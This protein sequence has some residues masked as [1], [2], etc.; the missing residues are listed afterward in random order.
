MGSRGHCSGRCSLPRAGSISSQSPPGTVTYSGLFMLT[1]CGKSIS[2]VICSRCCFQ[3]FNHLYSTGEF[4]RLPE[5]SSCSPAE[6]PKPLPLSYCTLQDKKL[7]PGGL[8]WQNC[9]DDVCAQPWCKGRLDPEGQQSLRFAS[10]IIETFMSSSVRRSVLLGMIGGR[11]T[12]I[13]AP[14]FTQHPHPHPHPHAFKVFCLRFL[15]C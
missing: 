8:F 4:A 15:L 14:C 5:C 11:M 10:L 7:R 3:R 9:T 12:D 2:N 1:S 13:T 6:C